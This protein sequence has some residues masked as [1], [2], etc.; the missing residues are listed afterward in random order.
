MA[1]LPRPE[2]RAAQGNRTQT[3]PSSV[4]Q[5]AASKAASRSSSSGFVLIGR[6]RPKT[7]S[8]GECSSA[9]R[10]VPAGPGSHRATSFST[11]KWI[12]S[13]VVSPLQAQPQ[14]AFPRVARGDRKS[15]GQRSVAKQGAASTCR[16]ARHRAS[17]PATSQPS[18][19][20]DEKSTITA[21]S[22]SGESFLSNSPIGPL[23]SSA[24]PRAANRRK[25]SSLPVTMVWASTASSG[26]G[27]SPPDSRRATRFA[28]RSTFS[29]ERQ[30]R[31]LA[32]MPSS[33]SRTTTLCAGQSTRSVE[34][35]V[36]PADLL[37][38]QV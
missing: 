14:F 33:N 19:R 36:E 21:R 1:L 24:S 17:W 28:P 32:S 20:A 2:P 37:R 31:R 38:P 18:S 6:L 26:C 29:P 4:S 9:R 34:A 22:P 5:R 11:S 30:I 13:A 27:Q 25:A 7:S 23:A 3:M 8:V 35:Q 12:F 10:C 16:A 15:H